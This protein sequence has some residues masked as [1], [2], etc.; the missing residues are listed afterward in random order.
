MSAFAESDH[1]TEVRKMI[2]AYHHPHL[3]RRRKASDRLRGERAEH[4]EAEVLG[5][6]G[7]HPI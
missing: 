2:E 5:G 6:E 1:F 3:R 4:G 7:G